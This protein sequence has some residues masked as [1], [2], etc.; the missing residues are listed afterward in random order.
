[1][2]TAGQPSISM[3][4]TGLTFNATVNGASPPVQTVSLVNSG[5]GT[6]SGLTIGSVAYAAGATGW[7]QPPVLDAT[8]ASP[9]A[10]LSA[11][12]IAGSLAAGTYTAS[13]PVSSSVAQ[14]SPQNVSV[15]FIVSAP[16]VQRLTL[17][18]TGAGTVSLSP[19]GSGTCANP[20][21][22]TCVAD[23]TQGQSVAMTAA[24]SSGNTFSGWSGT[25]SGTGACNIAMDQARNVTA[26]FTASAPA[27]ALAP[28]SITFNGATGGANPLSQ[29]VAVNNSGVGT[30]NGLSAGSIVYGPG[31]FGWLQTPTFS[32]FTAPATITLQSIIGALG[33][34]T[35]TATIPIASAVAAN[36]PQSITVTLN[37]V[38]SPIIALTPSFLNFSAPWLGGNPASQTSAVTNAGSGT[39]SGLS[40]GTVSY[41]PGGFGWVQSATLNSTTA[42]SL[43]AVQ[44]ATGALDPGVYTALVPIQSV[45]ASN[46]PRNVS[47]T[48]S[49][50]APVPA[51]AKLFLAGVEYPTSITFRRGNSYTMEVRLFAVDG[52][53]IT[54][55]PPGKLITMQMTGSENYG[56][57]GP[58][59]SIPDGF[60]FTA[61]I[62]TQF[63]GGSG[64]Y[65]FYGTAASPTA[66][67]LKSVSLTIAL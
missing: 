38:A 41:G 39:L 6:L 64:L 11:R 10:T 28:I 37:V 40:V 22:A 63:Y 9:S 52:S 54:K 19:L 31:A 21:S 32:T 60:H 36:S 62:G 2:D 27:I 47:V 20:A 46:S 48:F 45:V 30:L 34:G 50:V 14:N 15:T 25:C 16:V 44:P 59:A 58:A 42:V 53:P 65:I 26:T 8:T 3:T 35:Y 61:E 17:T 55:L 33:S 23:F 29:T 49:V 24:P 18:I 43:L 7:L 4:P 57:I 66:T 13:I 67:L 1:M 56:P 12:A 51:T 5:A